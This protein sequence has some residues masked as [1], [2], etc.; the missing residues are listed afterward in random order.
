MLED[1]DMKYSFSQRA[2]SPKVNL[3]QEVQ[4]QGYCGTGEFSTKYQYYGTQR[5]DI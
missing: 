3:A 2:Q 4:G 5:R 1:R